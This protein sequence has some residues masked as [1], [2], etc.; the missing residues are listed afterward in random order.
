VLS[1]ANPFHSAR[2]G[3]CPPH[4]SHESKP[5]RG[6]NRVSAQIDK[7]PKNIGLHPGPG[8]HKFFTV[9][10]AYR[11]FAAM[12]GLKINFDG[13]AIVSFRILTLRKASITASCTAYTVND[14]STKTPTKTP[15]NIQ[16]QTHQHKSPI[17][18]LKHHQTTCQ[19]A[20]QHATNNRRNTA[21]QQ[22]PTPTNK[23]H[24]QNQDDDL[25]RQ[26][27]TTTTC[28]DDP[29]RPPM[30]T[31]TRRRRRRRRRPTTTTHDDEPQRRPTTTTTTT[32]TEAID[33]KVG[34]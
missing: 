22:A 11:H 8:R 14:A 23:Q 24:N 5:H 28:D 6:A 1:R 17:N 12:D 10:S 21:H 2:M 18:Q 30:T 29:R 32:T 4:C 26:R 15:T 33:H 19:Q 13:N 3:R 7:L 34:K 20:H 9:N 16:N 27:P 31:T 25:P